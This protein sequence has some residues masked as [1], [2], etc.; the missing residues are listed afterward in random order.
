MLEITFVT[1]FVC[2][3]CLVGKVALQ[4]AIRATGI[5][6]TLKI[7]PMELTEE[8]KPR[9]DTYHD[10]VRREKYKILDEPA[11]ALG[12][13]MKIPPN[14]VPRPYTRLAWEGWFFAKKKGLGDPYSDLMYRAYF[15]DEKDIGDIDVLVALAESIGLDGVE[16]RNALDSGTYYEAERMASNYSRHNLEVKGIPTLFIN[17]HRVKMSDYSIDAAI[18]LLKNPPSEDVT[19]NSV[20]CGPDGCCGAVMPKADS[21]DGC[22]PD[23]CHF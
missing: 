10:P 6:A 9:V 20:G 4:E 21:N 13:D 12:L 8:P 22:G 17:G 5:E 16:Y 14:V 3:Y 19:N 18:E 1:D 23:G 11:K 2:P 7:Q 15:I